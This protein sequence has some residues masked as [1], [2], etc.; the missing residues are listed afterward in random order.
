MKSS[1]RPVRH[2]EPHCLSTN[3]QPHEDTASDGDNDAFIF[4]LTADMNMS[5]EQDADLHLHAL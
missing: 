3:V 4:Q 1:A 5:V 2:V